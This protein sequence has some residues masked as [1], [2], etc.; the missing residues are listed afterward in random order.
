MLRW[1]F[2]GAMIN[3]VYTGITLLLF[4]VG[5][6]STNDLCGL[7][8]GIANIHNSPMEILLGSLVPHYYSYYLFVISTYIIPFIASLIT[9]FIIGLIVAGVYKK[10]KNH[11]VM[12]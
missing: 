5:N 2:I 4:P 3:A 8:W 7:G 10:I 11:I 9:G 6:C 1:A 12:K